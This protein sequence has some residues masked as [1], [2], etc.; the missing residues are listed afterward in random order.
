MALV[1]T[2]RKMVVERR[3]LYL[4]YGC[5]LEDLETLVDFQITAS[6]N[7][8]EAPL[9]MSLA[10]TDA[11]NKKLTMFAAGGL[12]NTNY[13]LSMV[14]RTS[15]GQVKRDDIGLRVNP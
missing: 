15:D 10:Y 7:T 1:K 9:V 13:T 2:F 8:P 14:V 5:W 6:P 3:R 11:T 12:G 4:N